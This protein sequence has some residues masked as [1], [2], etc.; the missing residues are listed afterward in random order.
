MDAYLSEKEQIELLRQWVKKYGALI[1]FSVFLVLSISYA[2]R[3]WQ[4]MKT[5]RALAAS[6]LYQSMMEANLNSDSKG[7]D[8]NASQLIQQYSKTPYGLI[9]RLMLAREAINKGQL[10]VAS[11]YLNWVLDHGSDSM[12]KQVARNRLARIFIAENQPQKALDLL[13]KVEDSS[14]QAAIDEIKG[15]AF[16]ALNNKTSA[17]TAYQSA[18]KALPD[19]SLDRPLL[20]MKA[21]QLSAST[22]PSQTA[23]RMQT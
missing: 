12:L 18:L 3:V 19:Q 5:E 16:S 11:T 2:W 20:Q 21:N 10:E 23:T 13:K 6:A 9:A 7:M 4:N 17:S 8:A 15:D 1:L 22:E 14:Y